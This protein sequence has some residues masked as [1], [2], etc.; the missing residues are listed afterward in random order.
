MGDVGAGARVQ[1]G[2][3]LTMIG[4]TLAG[5]PEG[6]TLTQRFEALLAQLSERQDLDPDT[7]ELAIEKTKAVA[8]GLAQAQAA[9]GGLRK[10][11][12]DAK[13]FLGGAAGW[14]WEEL[15]GILKSEAAQKTIATISEATTR[16]AI[17][18]LTGMP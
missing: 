17:A 8:D 3:H 10:A 12:L 5:L 15:G 4:D 9:P 18:Q 14:A 7:K 16:T 13:Q 6:D 2:E 11:L 1:Q